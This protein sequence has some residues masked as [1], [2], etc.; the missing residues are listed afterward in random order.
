M[1]KLYCEVCKKEVETSAIPEVNAH[2]YRQI[3]LFAASCGHAFNVNPRGTYQQ[4]VSD[5]TEDDWG[6]DLK[7]FTEKELQMFRAHRKS[8]FSK[9]NLLKTLDSVVAEIKSMPLEELQ[10]Q[11][12]K[13]EGTVFAKTINMI[14]NGNN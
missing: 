2:T 10:K 4:V 6:S 5:R 9:A 12:K 1:I 13:S 11:L 14:I 3:A 8:E 7:V